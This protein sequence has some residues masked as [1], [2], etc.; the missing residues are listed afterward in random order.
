MTKNILD[1]IDPKD[2]NA[3]IENQI[4]RAK[5]IKDVKTKCQAFENITENCQLLINEILIK[6]K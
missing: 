3:F 5:Q 4:E 1:G 6:Q 2:A